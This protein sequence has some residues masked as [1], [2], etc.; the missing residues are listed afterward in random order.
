MSVTMEYYYNLLSEKD[1]VLFAFEKIKEKLHKEE[2]IIQLSTALISYMEKDE[3]LPKGLGF[4]ESIQ[5]KKEDAENAAKP[6]T[7][8]FHT[9]GQKLVKLREQ[10][11]TVQDELRKRGLVA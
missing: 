8:E 2:D 1:N 9:L 5:Q 7:E 4:I 10:C 6:L 3:T 11:Y